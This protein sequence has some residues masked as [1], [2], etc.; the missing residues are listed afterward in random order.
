MKVRISTLFLLAAALLFC[1]CSKDVLSEDDGKNGREDS[2]VQEDL[3]RLELSS[4]SKTQM[5]GSS[6]IWEASDNIIVNG[7]KCALQFDGK[8]AYV[9]VKGSAKYE[10]FYPAEL[11]DAE[12]LYVQ[13]SQFFRKDS[14]APMTNPMYAVADGNDGTLVFHH[15]MGILKLTVKGSGTVASISVKDNNGGAVC[16]C[17]TYNPDGNVITA[18]PVQ[19][20]YVPLNCKTSSNGGTNLT[21]AGVNF[22]VVMPARAYSKGLTINIELVNGHSM[23]V[24]SSTPRTI[25]SG[26]VLSTPAINFSY[27]PSQIYEYHLDNLVLGSD[28]VGGRLGFKADNPASLKGF[29]Y[30][31]KLTGDVNEDGTVDISTSNT[32]NDFSA[33]GKPYAYSRNIQ[34]MVK[35]HR[36]RECHGYFACG[37]GHE[38]KASFKF[39][40]LTNIGPGIH[41]V[42]YSFKMAFQNGHRPDI[43]IQ[44]LHTTSTAGKVLEL[45]VDGVN[46]SKDMSD[47]RR[48]LSGSS[49]GVPVLK[50]ASHTEER[51]MV[52]PDD[53]KN[54]F[55]WHDVKLVLGAVTA[56]TVLEFQAFGSN[57]DQPWYIDDIK[58]VKLEYADN[59]ADITFCE[60]SASTYAWNDNYA[61]MP[62]LYINPL[63]SSARNFLKTYSNLYGFTYIDISI[64]T[65]TLFGSGGYAIKS[66]S[67]AD[68][69]AFDKAVVTAK[70]ALDEMG[71]KVW[72]IHLPYEN[73]KEGS[74]TDDNAFELCST[75]GDARNAA[76]NRMQVVMK[77]LKPFAPKYWM[78]HTTFH[79]NWDFDGYTTTGILWWQEKTYYRDCGVLSFKSMV[80]YARNLKYSDGTNGSFTIE[81]LA[82]A[83]DYSGCIAG[84][85]DNM[86]WFC[87]QCPG[88]GI[89]LDTGHAVVNS[90]NCSDGNL[91][92]AVKKM[93]EKGYLKHLHV[94]GNY[95]GNNKD[96]HLLP[97]YKPGLAVTTSFSTTDTIDWAKTYRALID[98][99]YR[100]AFTYEYSSPSYGLDCRDCISSFPNIIHNYFDVILKSYKSN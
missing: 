89:C 92:P 32:N 58:A 79:H 57:A 41:K 46:V 23:Q 19:F 52:R 12:K 72:S 96:C 81:N 70:T 76:V 47:S 99:G 64:S 11:W 44:L 55:K 50:D 21:A 25:V 97:G 5:S 35:L 100:G 98:N 71:I 31:T 22:Y 13:P 27:D 86:I 49:D 51:I 15:L 91:G 20:P 87:D 48:W 90:I 26:T 93:C 2:A 68:W 38:A 29:E 56:K 28:P 80:E 61:L 77:H 82:N 36:T 9:L 14:F 42:E 43:G 7:E 3:V 83:G 45:Y 66:L 16:G 60:P 18:G 8:Q 24:V 4:D 94:H 34:S 85:V 10:A 17:Y 53:F 69:E 65:N 33:L 62:S 1:S 54:D 59:L 74:V 95:V 30:L 37:T 40:A 67:D 73:L 88:L 6:V 84:K 63:S 78:A 39:P 75:D